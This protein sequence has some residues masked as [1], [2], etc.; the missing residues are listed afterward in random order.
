MKIKENLVFDKHTGVLTGFFDLGDSDIK[1]LNI[2]DKEESLAT[3]AL[4][5]FHQRDFTKQ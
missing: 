1:C 2:K 3:H 5:F 4:V